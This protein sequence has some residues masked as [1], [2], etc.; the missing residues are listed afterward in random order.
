MKLRFFASVAVLVALLLYVAA[1]FF[2]FVLGAFWPLIA[3]PV[4]LAV[5]VGLNAYVEFITDSRNER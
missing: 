3:C 2:S 5:V 1:V 4:L